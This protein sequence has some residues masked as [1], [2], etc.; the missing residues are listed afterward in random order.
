[1]TD[2]ATRN[3]NQTYFSHLFHQ[4]QIKKVTTLPPIGKADHDIVYIENDKWFKRVREAPEKYSE[5]REKHRHCD[6]IREK[7]RK[8]S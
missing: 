3:D 1:M 7:T 6:A 2:K 5:K 8:A 4:A